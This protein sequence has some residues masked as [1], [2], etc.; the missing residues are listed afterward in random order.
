MRTTISQIP[1]SARIRIF[2]KV[3]QKELSSSISISKINPPSLSRNILILSLIFF[4]LVN[5][6]VS[7]T[8]SSTCTVKMK[9]SSWDLMRI[10]QIL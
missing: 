9:S 8:R 2:Q 6:L 10:L 5:R 7:R 1:N 3:E 4:Y